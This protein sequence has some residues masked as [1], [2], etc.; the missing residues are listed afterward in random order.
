MQI[1]ILRILRRNFCDVTPTTNAIMP[2]LTHGSPTNPEVQTSKRRVLP[3]DGACAFPTDP[4]SD[5]RTDPTL[6][7]PIVAPDVVTIETADMTA[8]P[9]PSGF[10]LLSEAIRPTERHLVVALGTARFRL[11]LC[12]ASIRRT[13]CL[14]V[15][16]DRFVRVRLAAAQRFERATSGRRIAP[17]P[18]AFP[19]IYRRSR[20]VR[21]LR[22]H[23]ALEA[24]KTPRTLAFD[25]IFPG[26]APLDGASWKG[27]GERRH[28]FRLIAEMRHLVNGNH[29]KLLRHD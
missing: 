8:V 20:I 14:I 27:S 25:L 23:D 15:T 12:A 7:S 26:Q 9:L 19:S 1:T 3:G 13:N 11:C 22:I 5:P 6:W 28:T 16:H 21:L 4:A 10:E 17:D 2:K 24:G 18:A 29:Q